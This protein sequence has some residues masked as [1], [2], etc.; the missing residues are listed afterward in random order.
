MAGPL[1]AEENGLR[2]S[3]Y[4]YP[5]DLRPVR[6][7]EPPTRPARRLEASERPVRP[8]DLRPKSCTCDVS[9]TPRLRDRSLA[10]SM[11]GPKRTNS[12]RENIAFAK[13]WNALER[14][15]N[16]ELSDVLGHAGNDVPYP[17][18]RGMLVNEVAVGRLEQ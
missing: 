4:R 13:T 12:K 9:S 8:V 7:W 1:W 15:R 18:W 16:C 3:K 10:N 6:A 14:S 11:F 17:E 5:L 2:R